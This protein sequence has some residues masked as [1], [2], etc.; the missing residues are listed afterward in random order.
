MVRN[1]CPVPRRGSVGHLLNFSTY[2]L[3]GFSYPL[4]PKSYKGATLLAHILDIWLTASY[5]STHTKD[6]LRSNVLIL[7]YKDFANAPA[8]KRP[9]GI[10]TALRRIL[11]RH[12][13]RTL[14]HEF[15]TFFLPHQFALGVTAGMDTIVHRMLFT[16]SNFRQGTASRAI[17]Q[18]DFQNM[19]NSVSRLTVSEALTAQFPHLLPVFHLL[20]PPQGNTVWM[21]HQDGTWASFRQCE[22][23]AQ[24]CPLSPFF[25]CLLWHSSSATYTHN[26]NNDMPPG[27]H[28]RHR[29]TLHHPNTQSP[30]THRRDHPYHPLAPN[31][32]AMSTLSGP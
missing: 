19:F 4:V 15:A 13:A 31:L 7:L 10:G 23:F 6:M 29:P 16:N 32:R 25:S 2:F 5:I 1:W 22:G 14:S 28:H 20:Y 27:C 12:I 26:S 9:M 18:L 3:R 24:G 8:K 30:T 21:Q 11:A 17:L